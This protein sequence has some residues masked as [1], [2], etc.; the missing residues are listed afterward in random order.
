MQ[1]PF[2]ELSVIPKLTRR[3]VIFRHF[4]AHVKNYKTAIDLIGILLFGVYFVFGQ[5][6]AAGPLRVGATKVDLEEWNG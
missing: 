4:G 5:T 2:A 1:T 6:V 3:D